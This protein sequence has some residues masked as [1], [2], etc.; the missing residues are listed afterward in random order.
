MQRMGDGALENAR[1]AQLGDGLAAYRRDTVAMDRVH[2]LAEAHGRWPRDSYLARE[3]VTDV[4]GD[5][6][7]GE[8]GCNL[9][10]PLAPQIEH[11][12]QRQARRLRNP[13]AQPRSRGPR[14]S[15]R[16]SRLR[17]RVVPLDMAPASALAV[18]PP[19]EQLI[20]PGYAAIDPVEWVSLIR[21]RA[22]G[23]DAAE[24]L[25]AIYDREIY[26]RRQVLDAGM[27]KQ[28]YRTAKERLVQ[29]ASAARE[30]L[31]AAQGM[32]SDESD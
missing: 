13:D 21:D 26:P 10:R 32:T 25:L 15:G 14:K 8:L 12:V 20:E 29:Y 19:Q 22:A 7:V 4:I 17:N 23:D 9:D 30:L 16:S 6:F 3:V 2:R 5:I 11:Y 31:F 28:S 1:R 24:Q 18:D 27:T